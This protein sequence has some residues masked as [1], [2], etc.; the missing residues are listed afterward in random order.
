MLN[1]PKFMSPSINMYG[2]SVIDLNSDALPFSCIVDGNEPIVKWQI[3]I[4][5]LKDNIEVL[6]TGEQTLDVSFQPVDNRNRNNKFQKNLSDYLTE[7]YMKKDSEG[8]LLFINSSDAYYW[9]IRFWGESGYMTASCEEVFYANSTPII[10][11]KYSDDGV[12]YSELTNAQSLD[13]RMYYFKAD[14]SQAEGMALKKYGWRITDINNDNVILN[15]ID[16][17]QIYGSSGNISCQHNGFVNDNEY[18]IELFIETQN[19]YF[20]VVK[21]IKFS[22]DYTVKALLTDFGI[23]AINSSSCIMLDWGDLKTTE[24]VTNG[25]DVTRLVN[26]PITKYKPAGEPAGTNSVKIEDGSSIV[27]EGN[28]NTKLEIP[29]DSYVVLSFQITKDE[30]TTL[31]EMSGIDEYSYSVIKTLKYISETKTLIHSIEKDNGDYAVKSIELTNRPRDA[32]WYVVTLSPLL[33]NADGE[34]FT[35]ISVVESVADSSL[36]PD[37][38]ALYPSDDLYPDDNLYPFNGKWDKLKGAS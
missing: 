8:N 37:D 1:K 3:I 16:S 7:I 31:L 10:V 38:V 13:K 21:C 19:G 32:A 25:D 36:N 18:K 30:D 17:N 35:D 26:Y 6:D 5:R 22:V 11:V 20:S 15:T 23:E 9:K 29:E 33:K 12:N 4:S 28:T 34:C 2:N 24:G 27:F 14:Y